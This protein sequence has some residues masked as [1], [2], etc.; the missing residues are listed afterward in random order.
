MIISASRRTDIPAF[1]GEWFMGR[2][3]EGY[4]RRVNPFNANQ[5]SLYRLNPEEVDAIVLFSK[6]PRPFLR[7]IDELSDH[8]Y[9]FLFHFTLNDYPYWIEPGVPEIGE[10][11]RTFSELNS[12]LGRTRII[13]RYDPIILSS[14]TPPAFHLEKIGRLAEQLNGLTERLTISFMDFYP[15]INPRLNKLEQTHG[16][17]FRDWL[18]DDAVE[19]L[20]ELC[21]GIQAIAIRNNLTVFSCAEPVELLNLGIRR[22]SCIDG[23]LIQSLFK[24][25]KTFKKD[26]HQRPECLCA[27]S[28]DMGIYNTC[29]LGCV[30]CYANRDGKMVEAN[31]ARYS[32]DSA[33]L[34]GDN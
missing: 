23:N 7:Y 16:I 5:S 8:G 4:F 33:G 9:N 19:E 34:L 1:F 27:Q 31:M 15:K 13:W 24:P 2:I 26:P 10:R 30:Y 32:P 18:Q 21:S 29:R 3:R 6:N 11:I 12:K 28:V 22:G 20:T 14:A 17:I 25:G